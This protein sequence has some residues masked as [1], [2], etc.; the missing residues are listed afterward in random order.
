MNNMLKSHEGLEWFDFWADF[1]SQSPFYT[2]PY[3]EELINLIKTLGQSLLEGDS[4]IELS[5]PVLNLNEIIASVDTQQAVDKPLVWDAP[6][7]YLQR[8][9]QLERQLAQRIAILIQHRMQ[10]IAVQPYLAL[11]NDPYQQQALT[12]GVNSSFAMITG[13][14]GTGKTYILTRIVAVLKHFQP[15]LRIAMAAPTGKAAQRMQEALQLAF[16]DPALQQANLY[17]T[18]LA[19]QQTQTLH[20]L[21]GMGYRQIP[22]YNQ[23]HPL[24]Y[25][26]IVV[27]EAS[28]LDLTLAH[29]LL[30]ALHSSTR[31]ILLGDANQLSSVDVGYVLADLQQVEVLQNYRVQLQTSR[32]FSDQAQIGRFARFIYQVD[33]PPYLEQWLQQV[34]P[35]IIKYHD[36]CDVILQENN[37]QQHLPI[38][39]VGYYPIDENSAPSEDALIYQKLAQGYDSYIQA[40]KKYRLGTMNND[41]LAQA[42]DGYRILVAMRTGHLGLERMNQLMTHYIRQQLQIVEP[43]EWFEGRAVMMIYNDD[44]LGLSNGDIGIC[45]KDHLHSEQYVVYF[46]SLKRVIAAARLPQSMQTAFALTIHKSQG[47]EFRHVAVVLDKLAQQLLS[48]ELLYTAVTRAKKMVSIYAHAQALEL[49]LQRKTSRCSGL[50]RQL[51]RCL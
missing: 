1:L 2:G 44:Q 17:H 35:E 36:L 7:L 12:I 28:M 45:L 37:T 13:G 40:V 41:E 27:D 6:Y 51:A 38:D 8:Y 46:P 33:Q 11:F 23:E 10:P 32:R 50:A 48:K 24:P 5:A 21:L 18:D 25:D 42:F 9:W 14:P 43:G 47:S 22:K 15:E 4:C 16:N 26:V 29:A 19:Q 30:N 39:W 20:R 34:K 31:L 3:K 49:S